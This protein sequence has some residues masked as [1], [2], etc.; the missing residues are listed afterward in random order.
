MNFVY[1]DGGGIIDTLA[2]EA[3]REGMDDIRYATLLQKLAKPLQ[4]SKDYRV[5][6]VARKA[7][8]VLAELDTDSFDLSAAR[9]EIIRH[10]MALKSISK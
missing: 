6:D 8:Q 4:H 10:I 2:W 5:R 3:F 1:G 7:M 9:L